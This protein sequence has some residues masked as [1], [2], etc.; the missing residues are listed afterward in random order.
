MGDGSDVTRLKRRL[1]DLDE[2]V[3]SRLDGAG[4]QIGTCMRR[5]PGS[6]VRNPELLRVLRVWP[7]SAPAAG[8]EKL[9]S[10]P[11]DIGGRLRRMWG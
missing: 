4:D 9:A 3:L 1:I 10:D 11:V 8:P 5:A 6:S 2:D 7:A